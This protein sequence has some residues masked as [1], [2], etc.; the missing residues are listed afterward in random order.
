MSR[1]TLARGLCAAALLIFWIVVQLLLPANPAT[2]HA[3]LESDDPA[4][5]ADLPTAPS[6]IRSPFTEPLETSYSWAGLFDRN[7][8]AVPGVS[9]RVGPDPWS[10]SVAIPTGLTNGTYSL[11]WR[12]LS[13]VD[14]HTVQGSL[15]EGALSIA[16][17]L[18]FLGLAAVTAIWPIW[19]F[20]V[21]PAIAPAWQLGPGL[22]RRVRKYAIY[23]FLFALFANI[24]ALVAQA[25]AISGLPD[26]RNGLM[27]TLGDTRYGT[28][29]L[30]RVGVLLVFA[31]VLLGTAWWWPW[32]RRP[33]TVL[34]L[35]AS[36][37]LPLPF[38][39]I[40][41]A[42]AEPAGQA[43]AVAFDYVHLLGVS[44]WAGGLLFLLVA[45]GP[46]VR[47]LTAAGRRVVLG[48]AIPRFSLLALIAWGVMGLTGLYSA[49][50]QV[51][52]IPA[53]TQTPYGQTLILKILLIVPLL[54][55]GAFNFAIVAR[56]L[57]GAATEEHVEGWSTRFVTALVAEVVI[58]IL[59]LGV[60]GML[61]GTP[62]ARQVLEQQA[63]SVRIALEA[64][65]QTGTLIITPGAAGPNR[66]RLELG[67][68]HEAHLR[69]PAVTDATLRFNLPERRMGQI[70]VPLVS[71]PSGGFEGRGS[72]LAFPGNWRMQLTVLMPGQPDWVVATNIPISASGA[73]DQISQPPP[74]FGPAGIAAL[75][76]LV[77]GISGM[78][79]ALVGGTPVFRKAAA[80]LGAVVLVAGAVLLFQAQ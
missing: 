80:G 39:M 14:G 55:L 13:T 56:K 74:R 72:E 59:L 73:P 31:A 20:V 68:G 76:L 79:F 15:L 42:A 27:T 24:V 48:R 21:R 71:A 77:L 67:Y 5:N 33:A 6:I 22:T 75:A 58:V 43:T 1:C 3:F 17:W 54:L 60:V 64:D 65:G 12:T 44:L 26:L 57:R 11:L 25:A 38:S 41:H 16:N 62:P 63:G 61:I 78:A 34:A 37:A 46:I 49:W 7:R 32:Q 70:D 66:Y 2:A 9:S 50:L 45:L 30:V 18:A 53:L 19:L 28:W 29:W 35:I 10:M 52:S 47:D 69:N 40:S 8:A 4:A 36:A 51:G 23:A